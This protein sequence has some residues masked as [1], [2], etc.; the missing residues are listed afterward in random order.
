MGSSANMTSFPTVTVQS[1][2]S[3]Y[4][5][6]RQSMKLSSVQFYRAGGLQLSDALRLI[7]ETTTAQD[8]TQ[9]VRINATVDLVNSIVAVIH[10][11]DEGLDENSSS[12]PSGNG[13]GG[14]SSQG[15]CNTAGF[16]CIVQLDPE[17][18]TLT[19]LSPCPGTL[20]SRQLLV[21]SLKWVE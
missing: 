10:P 15:P 12:V 3:T 6:S 11:P 4:F 9:L 17:T 2:S 8:N 18:D 7:G 20:P 21:G 19:V 1:L 16:L 14:F 13:G 5:P